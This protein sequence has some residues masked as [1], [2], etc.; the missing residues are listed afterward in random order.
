MKIY[1]EKT[2]TAEF[3]KGEKLSKN[4]K[5][6]LGTEVTTLHTLILKGYGDSV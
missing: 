5:W 4:E 3:R 6:R 1:V 2:K